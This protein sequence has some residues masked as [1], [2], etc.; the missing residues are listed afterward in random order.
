MK[1]ECFFVLFDKLHSFVL[2]TKH[3]HWSNC[4]KLSGKL[5]RLKNKHAQKNLH[6]SWL[7][8]NG[9]ISYFVFSFLKQ[10]KDQVRGPGYIK[11]VK[12]VV[13]INDYHGYSPKYNEVDYGL[14]V[15]RVEMRYK[16][17]ASV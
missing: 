15:V 4:H 13:A 9:S 14:Q 16:Q 6:A 2:Q 12:N 7:N 3:F 5:S 11:Y 17:L 10:Y 1:R 8:A